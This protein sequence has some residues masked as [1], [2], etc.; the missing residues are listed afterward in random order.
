[1]LGDFNINYL[2]PTS[3]LQQEVIDTLITQN[4]INTV[5]LPTYYSYNASPSLLDHTWTNINKTF[6]SFVFRDIIADHLPTLTIFDT[7]TDTCTISKRKISFRDFSLNNIRLLQENISREKQNF[8]NNRC[9]CGSVDCE[10]VELTEW[11]R[12]L[13]NTYTPI[14]VKQVHS[15]ETDLPW[16]TRNLKICIKNK[17]KLFNCFVSKT[18]NYQFFSTYSKALKIL[19]FLCERRYLLNQLHLS[20]K[21]P[22]LKWKCLNKILNCNKRK[23]DSDTLKLT[24]DNNHI[25]S[26]KELA[27][28]F[29]DYFISTP[30]TI[31]N[32]L[33]ITDENLINLVPFNNSTF[34]FSPTTPNEVNTIIKRLKNCNVLFDIPAKLLK[35]TADN[36]S[37]LI[38][39]LINHCISD[40]CY[41]SIFKTAKVIPLFKKGC[42]SYLGNYRPISLLPSL[43]KIF[44]KV[45]VSRLHSFILEYNLLSDNQYGFRANKD[46]SQAAI[47]LINNI[48]PAFHEKKYSIALF[49]DFQKAF[50]TLDRTLLFQK[51][52]RKGIRGTSLNLIRSYFSDR[53]QFVHINGVDSDTKPTNIGTIQ[54]S[55]LG[56]LFY[57]LYADDLNYLFNDNSIKLV[58]YADD[59][60]ITLYG[61]DI[62]LLSIKMKMIVSRLEVWSN[63]NKLA[64]N[65][66]KT[67]FMIFSPHT[68]YII[69]SLH[70]YNTAV[71]CVENFTYLGIII[72]SKLRF[73]S[74]LKHT[75]NKLNRLCGISYHKS[76]VFDYES[77]LLFYYSFVYSAISYGI[78]CW[79]GVFNVLACSRAQNLQDRIL[80]NLFGQFYRG[81]NTN[82][83]YTKLHIL[84]CKD[85][86]QFNLMTLFY[87]LIHRF[88]SADIESIFEP[89]LN[90]HSHNTR[91]YQEYIVP[92]PRIN[93]IKL[94]FK[95]QVYLQWNNLP[96]SIKNSK[97]LSS[98]KSQLKAHYLNLYN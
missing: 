86:Y 31:Q 65:V 21:Q 98:F 56:P 84:K 54:G 23:N 24:V 8:I 10:S 64:L 11:L 94:N 36:V 53:S 88:Y 43:N 93:T 4:F 1:M 3:E 90:E 32:N 85:I 67:K 26:P 12:H 6:T 91:R 83:L 47:R 59:T 28:T 77:S 2:H 80:R 71:E 20:N 89:I 37:E 41:P 78:C 39:N 16:M 87:K 75:E 57:I 66:T 74:H 55:N 70:L 40:A 97:S 73:S 29:N 92:F 33:R 35:F 72:D 30:L 58:M 27:K 46:T 22:K 52:Y 14:K 45:I 68:G 5:S 15:N 7:P 38:S 69:P 13:S 60:A 61:D 51:L 63:F 79:G 25:S 18:I 44:E 48:L 81:C 95:Y 50:D 82:E 42:K 19:M 62:N 34:F 17:H 96:V 49:L 76:K 9:R